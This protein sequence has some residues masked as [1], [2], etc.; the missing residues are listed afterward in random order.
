MIVSVH[1][2]DR[3][4]GSGSQTLH[5]TNDG[6][7]EQ[8]LITP[9]S[10]TLFVPLLRSGK[11]SNT[12]SNLLVTEMIKTKLAHTTGPDSATRAYAPSEAGVDRRWK[13]KNT[14]WCNYSCYALA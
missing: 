3:S 8:R 14:D 6:T 11:T 9:I 13:E 4:H 12:K 2:R 1:W 5:G 7:I 10:I